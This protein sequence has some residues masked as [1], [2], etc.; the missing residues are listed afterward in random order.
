MKNKPCRRGIKLFIRNDSKTGYCH[1][2]QVYLGKKGGTAEKHLYFRVVNDLT[3]TLH[4]KNHKL[5]TDNLY[6]SIG[7]AVYLL[8]KKV[9]L[10]GTMRRLRKG[11]PDQVNNP[12]KL[13]R[14]Q[15]K[16]F[17]S[18]DNPNLSSCVWA[19]TATVRF[20][21][22][23]ADPHGKTTQ[24]RRVGGERVRVDSPKVAV[25]YLQNYQ[26]TDRFD[27]LRSMYTLFRKTRKGVNYIM[28]FC[29]NSSIVNA[30][31]IYKEKSTRTVRKRYSN[32]EFRHELAQLLIG[33]FSCRA[34]STTRATFVGPE[35]PLDT[36]LT[37]QNVNLGLKRS[38]TCYW[39]RKM[40]PG[41]KWRR[42]TIMGCKTC[43]VS[44]CREGCH[45][46]F[47]SQTDV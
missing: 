30:W 19:D 9:F 46:A 31:L 15:S 34:R 2:F 16:S 23:C 32:F 42:E 38:R 12:G 43:N 14:G 8:E 11:L 13:T 22:T 27:R 17:Q 44:L 28:K 25:E 39:H 4:G 20:L 41:G 29:L 18:K 33:T 47:H 6:T 36:F 37:H 40:K 24:M 1:Q 5:Y 45:L 35:N 10:T 7:L 26:G 3:K 21:S